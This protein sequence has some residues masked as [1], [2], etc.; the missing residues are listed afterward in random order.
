MIHSTCEVINGCLLYQTE[1]LVF[2]EGEW[3]II[4]D[5]VHT[6][7]TS[8][9]THRCKPSKEDGDIKAS[10]KYGEY[11]WTDDDNEIPQ[12]VNCNVPVPES[13]I[14]LIRIYNWSR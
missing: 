7:H 8:Y 12:C 13:I 4:T 14:T 10:I 3:G 9:G 2:E 5:S 1:T 11:S 6:F